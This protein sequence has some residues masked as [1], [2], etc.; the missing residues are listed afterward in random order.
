MQNYDNYGQPTDSPY[1]TR[2]STIQLSNLVR[3]NFFRR[4]C[5]QM[6]RGN[7]CHLSAFPGVGATE[8][9]RRR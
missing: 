5:I 1:C 2:L 4:L 6:M 7:V 8:G 9:V 3:R